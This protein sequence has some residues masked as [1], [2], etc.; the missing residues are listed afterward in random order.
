MLV[1]CANI[2]NYSNGKAPTGLHDHDRVMSDGLFWNKMVVGAK[3]L[4]I[5][6]MIYNCKYDSLA[7]KPE[8]AGTNFMISASWYLQFHQ[9]SHSDNN[10]DDIYTA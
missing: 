1:E 9:H 5:G 7:W 4:D 8:T 3:S 10:Q 6:E 2:N